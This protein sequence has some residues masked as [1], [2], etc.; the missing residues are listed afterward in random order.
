MVTSLERGGPPEQTIVLATHLAR[1]GVQ[2]T[3][4]CAT[5]ALAARFAAGG[6]EPVVLPL[7]H[8][9][10]VRQAERIRRR[11]AGFDV[12][13]AQ[14]R[15]SGLWVRLWPRRRG[16]VKVYT[17]RGLPDAYLP[18]PAS[19]GPPSVRDRLAYEWLEPAL[20]RRA[21]AVVVASRAVAAILRERLNFP[22]DRLTV[23][24]N[25]VEIP[26]APKAAGDR[27]AAL[28]VL[29]PVKGLDVFVRAAA[30]LAARGTTSPFTVFGTGSLRVEL[31]RLSAELGL[32]GRMGFPGHVPSSEA[33]EQT[34]VLVMPSHMENCPNALLEAMAAGVPIVASRVG[35]VPELVDD[36]CAE[37]VPPG[38]PGA[39]ADA[40]ERLL[41]DPA[42]A[43]RQAQAARA[44]VEAHFTAERNA[45]A[46]LALYTRLLAAHDAAA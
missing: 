8:A 10:D 1:A 9:L 34:A 36:A 42:L 23:I 30:L 45:Q 46:V 43:R 31:E 6:A 40:I 7:R 38:D 22:A 27:V 13:H 21:D 24:P 14:D 39:L 28:G 3:A 20:C 19:S 44:R 4:V 29:E 11:L 41:G 37:L 18:P 26:P 16:L 32:D 2:V 12:V 5:S 33:L 17:V 35:G 15:R 25:G